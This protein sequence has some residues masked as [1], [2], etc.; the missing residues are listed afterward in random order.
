MV[1]ESYL[2]RL[3]IVLIY[4]ITHKVKTHIITSYARASAS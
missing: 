3:E 4:L 2:L 1:F